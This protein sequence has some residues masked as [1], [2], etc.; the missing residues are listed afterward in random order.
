MAREQRHGDPAP[1]ESRED[2]LR[3]ALAEQRD[4]HEATGA[5]ATRD[6]SVRRGL[7]RT[8]ALVTAGS[9][10]VGL[11]LWAAGASSGMAVGLGLAAVVVAG[12]LGGYP[13]LAVEDGRIQRRAPRSTK[14]GASPDD[15]P[16][17]AL[18][19]AL[20][21]RTPRDDAARDRHPDIYG[22]TTGGEARDRPQA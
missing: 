13:V 2:T 1:S 14:R 10:V 5:S 9:L 22:G 20:A 6:P 18:D 8:L 3:R 17:G 12:A 19:E 15:A 4:V 11:V 21:A 7:D 16:P